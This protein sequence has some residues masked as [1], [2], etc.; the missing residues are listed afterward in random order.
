[1]NGRSHSPAEAVIMS[2]L[3]IV[4]VLSGYGGWFAPSCFGAIPAI[5]VL[6]YPWIVAFAIVVVLFCAIVRRWH[7]VVITLGAIAVTWPSLSANFPLNMPRH[8]VGDSCSFKVMSFNV[9]GFDENNRIDTTRL[10]ENMRVILDEDADFVVMIQPTA[11]GLGYD[12][13]KSIA[14]WLHDIDNQYPYR[15]RSRYD[16][17]ELLSKYPFRAIPLTIPELSY[18]YWPYVIKS[19]NSFAF[20]ID[21][22]GRRLRLI[23]AYMTSF[24]LDD[25]ER[26]ILDTTRF[27]V[28][29]VPLLFRKLSN[30]FVEREHLTKLLRD[31]LDSGPRNVIFCT[32]MND[33]PQSFAYRTI[34]GSDMKD[35]FSQCNT[36]PVYTFRDHNMLFHID[37]I[38]FRGDMRAEAYR[39]VKDGNSDHY[40]IMAT[41]A[42]R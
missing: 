26:R 42:W 37:H 19:T 24:M 20:D 18:R 27:H 21:L 29:H 10:H 32:D 6:A 35:A 33:V 31:S 30:A 5:L 14:P 22:H 38:M 12:E 17:V 11:F 7:F 36:G 28:G 40:P 23:A 39:L 3:I 34:M 2:M 25:D 9:A 4:I 15:T 8:V 13:R 1:M 16:G 41:F